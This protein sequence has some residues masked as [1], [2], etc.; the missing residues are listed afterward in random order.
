MSKQVNIHG[1]MLILTLC[2]SVVVSVDAAPAVSSLEQ[3][4]ELPLEELS[5]IKVTVASRFSEPEL[6]V[7]STTAVIQE[8]DWRK[9]GAQRLHDAISHLPSTLILPGIFG[10]DNIAIRGYAQSEPSG[11]ATLW[12]GVPIS[13]LQSGTAQFDRNNIGLFTL[14]R[15]EMIRGPGSALYGSDAFHGVFSLHAF[16][17]ESDINRVSANLGSNDYYQGGIQYSQQIAEGLR[18]NASAALSGQSEQ[19]RTYTYTDIDTGLAASAERDYEYQSKTAVVKL[20]SD[21]DKTFAYSLGLYLDDNR[22]E[23]FQGFG[24][25]LTGGSSNLAERDLS[26]NDSEFHMSKF[27]MTRKF[28]DQLS[29]EFSGYYWLQDHVFTIIQPSG[30]TVDSDAEENQSGLNLTVRQPAERRATQWSLDFGY[31]RTTVEANLRTVTAPDGSIV[32]SGSTAVE[33]LNRDIYSISLDAATPLADESW[34]LAYG[35]RYDDYSDFGSHISPRLGVIYHSQPDSA[36]KLLYGHAFRAPF[37]VELVGTAIIKGDPDIQPETID[38]YELVFAEHSKNWK[39]ELVLF[40][41]QWKDGIITVPSLPPFP[42]EFVNRGENNAQGIEV[43]Y[44]LKSGAWLFDTS[45]SYV[46]SENELNNTDYVAFPKVIFNLGIGYQLAS[47]LDIFINNR[48]HLQVKE[49]PVLDSIPNPEPLPD[50]WRTDVNITKKL[51]GD[52]SLFLNIRNLFDRDNML[53][54]I[55]NSE[56]GIP[57]ESFNISAGADYLF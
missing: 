37:G 32:S 44:L 55:Q 15:I 2:L 25:R 36:I 43:S 46:E 41:S 54:S 23:D 53:P 33:G 24:T 20:V 7:S 56:N 11:I 13:T 42:Q 40:A 9:R 51:S 10:G 34:R 35:A 30:N 16:E 48:V 26:G 27:S 38:T 52:W 17:S 49:G 3:L 19:D 50:Y 21:P 6:A 57:D 31:R 47:D 14:D 39:T 5:N 18:L 12:D 29:A 45:A 8:K 1:R 28:S 4:L 22:S